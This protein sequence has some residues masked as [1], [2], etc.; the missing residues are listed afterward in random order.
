MLFTGATAPIALSNPVTPLSGPGQGL[1][2]NSFCHRA[3]TWAP[4]STPS[5][6]APVS[7]YPQR[8]IASFHAISTIIMRRIRGDY[9]VVRALYHCV[10]RLSG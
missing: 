4:R 10:S 8:I 1:K 9:A 6:T 2:L 3:E 5:G 7:T